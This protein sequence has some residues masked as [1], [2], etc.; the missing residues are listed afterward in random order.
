[1]KRHNNDYGQTAMMIY[2][3]RLSYLTMPTIQ[4]RRRYR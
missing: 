4:P 1:M 3:M 2:V